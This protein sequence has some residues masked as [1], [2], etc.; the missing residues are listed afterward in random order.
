MFRSQNTNTGSRVTVRIRLDHKTPAEVAELL[1]EYVQITK[2]QH[3]L[4]SYCQNM[5]RSQNTSTGSLVT[6]RIRSDHKTPTL[7]AEL[8]LEYVQITKH[9]HR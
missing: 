7:V 2:H 1:L 3:R 9:Q 6:V 8:L 5:F 4:P